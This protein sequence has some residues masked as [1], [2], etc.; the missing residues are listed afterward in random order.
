[1]DQLVRRRALHEPEQ[2]L[3]RRQREGVHRGSRDPCPAPTHHSPGGVDH[4]GEARDGRR[5]E[6]RAQRNAR[7]E[8]IGDARVNV[9]F[10]APM[11]K[12]LLAAQ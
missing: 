6:Q 5:V 11:Q 9:R 4:P 10:P 3:G 2:L 12:D 7:P 1:M 8:L